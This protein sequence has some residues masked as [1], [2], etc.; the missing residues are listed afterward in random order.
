[1]HSAGALLLAHGKAHIWAHSQAVA[2]AIAPIAARYGLDAD[3]CRTAAYCHDI[4]GILPPAEMLATARADGMPLDPAEERHPFLLHQ[5]FSALLCRERL[6]IADAALCTAV[7][8]HTTLRGH[9][10]PLDMALFIADKLAWDQ[11]GTP[12]YLDAVQAA[13]VASL[14]GACLAYI[15]YVMENGMILMPHQWLLQA[16]AWLRETT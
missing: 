8:C 2:Q 9:A 11:P 16:R 3:T 6:G 13:L 5:R 7:G 4:G 12:P 10:T 15:D 14:P 1:M